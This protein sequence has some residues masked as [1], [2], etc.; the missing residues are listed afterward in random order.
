M[1]KI[2]VLFLMIFMIISLSGCFPSSKPKIKVGTFDLVVNEENEDFSSGTLIITSIT[3]KE[4]DKTEDGINVLKTK[5]SG[6]M[7]SY[8]YK[9]EVYL[10]SKI[11]NQEELVQI[12]N[13]KFDQGYHSYSGDAYLK[14]Q[15]KEYSG[16]LK[17]EYFYSAACI[18][19]FDLYFDFELP[20]KTESVEKE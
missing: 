5:Y 3:K 8:H 6:N 11:S 19:C 2:A 13:F 7:T 10:F 15:D 4:Y 1:K 17:L 18:K 14:I 12:T 9:I 16:R 20:E